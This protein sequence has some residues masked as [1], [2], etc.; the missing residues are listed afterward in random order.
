MRKSE[1]NPSGFLDSFGFSKRGQ[2]DEVRIYG[3]ALGWGEVSTLYTSY[4]L[5]SCPP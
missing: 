5:S 1:E 4:D 2:I 3:R